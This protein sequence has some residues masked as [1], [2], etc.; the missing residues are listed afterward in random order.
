MFCSRLLLF[1]ALGVFAGIL[2]AQAPDTATLKGQVT[3]ESHAAVAGVQ[4]TVR[5]TLTN[6]ERYAH[7][8][9]LGSFS[10]SGLPIGSYALTVHK[11]GF[12]EASGELTLVAGT[13]ASRFNSMFRPFKT[14]FW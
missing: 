7:S 3:D 12:A 4:I 5:S 14:R 11:D 2:M 10:V 13:T 6:L 8:D 1:G 9:L